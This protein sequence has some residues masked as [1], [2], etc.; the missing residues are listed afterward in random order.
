MN[1]RK[2][3]KAST[4]PTM[5]DVA[6]LAGVSQA[7]VSMVLNETG[8]TRVTEKTR[9]LVREA[10]ETLGYRVWMRA[11]V[12]QGGIQ[13]IGF[14]IDDSTSNPITNKAIE[15]ARQLA[16]ENGAVLVVLP[17]QNDERL[18]AAALELLFAHR[19]VG[20]VFAAFFTRQ[21]TLP[22]KL[23]PTALTSDSRG[24]PKLLSC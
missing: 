5:V 13:A 21:Y 20:V 6:K 22:Q 16:W 15:S 7:T 4:R 17:T 11:P 2:T 14:I 9:G 19:V 3:E 10:A 18:R 24:I 12:G 23:I 1:R 8:G